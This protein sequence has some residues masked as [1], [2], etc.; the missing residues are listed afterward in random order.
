MCSVMLCSGM[1]CSVM[2][3]H[4]LFCPVMLCSRFRRGRGGGTPR[5]SRGFSGQLGVWRPR[6]AGWGCGRGVCSEKSN[7]PNLS[8]GEKPKTLLPPPSSHLL[9]PRGAS[10]P[11]LGPPSAA[12][13]G[14]LWAPGRPPEVRTLG[15]FVPSGAP[16]GA[17]V[18]A[19]ALPAIRGTCRSP[20]FRRGRGGGT[21][22][23][24]RGF[25]GQLGVWRPRYAGWGCGRGVCSKKSNN[26]NLSGGEQ[27]TNALWI[28]KLCGAIPSV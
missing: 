17:L 20:R 14:P 13:G 23:D 16:R 3:C 9:P 2:L 15:V 24:S 8:G 28:C 12:P 7:N 27:R 22:R 11:P 1:C 18:A 26:P 10:G 6:Y 5:D 25:S 19:A 4:A 21:P